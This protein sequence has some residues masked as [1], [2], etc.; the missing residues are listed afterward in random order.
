MLK[1]SN[2]NKSII[3]WMSVVFNSIKTTSGYKWISLRLWGLVDSKATLLS[4]DWKGQVQRL[5]CWVEIERDKFKDCSAELR[6]K[7][8]SSK[9]ALLSWDWKGQVQRLLCWVEIERDKFRL[10]CW[11]EIERDKFR[12][13]SA[14]LRLK[15]DKFRD[16]FAELRLKGDKFRDCSAELRLK[17]DKF[18]DCSAEMRLKGT[19]SDTAQ[20]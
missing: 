1:N 8:T 4:W 10:L 2:S 7:G 5:L 19:S 20:H 14:E 17:G 11:V 18:R 15:G 16:C 13:C 6:L 12:D 9:T 3:L